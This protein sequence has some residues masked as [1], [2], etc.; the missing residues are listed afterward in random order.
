MLWNECETAR[1]AALSA[2]PRTRTARA[3][4]SIDSSGALLHENRTALSSRTAMV[5]RDHA[6]ARRRGPLARGRS[7]TVAT[8]RT[9]AESEL[10]G[11]V[12]RT[13]R[14]AR[15][16]RWPSRPTARA[17][18]SPTR[19]PGRSRWWIPR[20]RGCSTSSRPVTSPRGGP[21]ADG[22]RGVVTHW[23]GYDLAVLEIKDDKIAVAGRVEVGP[24]PRGV[25]IDGRWRDRLRG[26]GRQQRSG[27]RRSRMPAR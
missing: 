3:A 4:R 6:G 16:S 10:A 25:A 11:R 13:S 7:P 23:Y 21:L 27:P 1:L 24:E 5:A 20:P 26:R 9:G 22:R 17:S 14:I 19:P 2:R 8:R 18:W 12:A 15:R